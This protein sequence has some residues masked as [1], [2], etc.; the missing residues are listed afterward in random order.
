MEGSKAVARFIRVS[1]RKAR[2]VVDLIRGKDLAKAQQI[3]EYTPRAAA[4]VVAKVL[5]SAAAN[6][7]NNA[8]MNPDDLFVATVYVD[9]GP[10]LKRFRPRAMGRATRINKR[11]SHITIILEEK[12]SAPKRKRRFRR[13]KPDALE[14]K[15]KKAEEGEAKEEKLE[16][17][18]EGEKER[19]AAAK[20]AA[21]KKKAA[22]KKAAPKK[23][24]AAKKVAPK[25]ATDDDSRKQAEESGGGGNETDTEKGES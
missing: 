9:E 10:T 19:K 1:P 15:A 22:A 18:A 4:R 6:A 2:L 17:Q 23:K 3:L 14:E 20:K 7:E 8:K 24:A 16:E 12:V 13:R 5:D 25:K 11:T 21:P